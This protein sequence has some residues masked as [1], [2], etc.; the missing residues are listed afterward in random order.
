M[1]RLESHKAHQ[2]QILLVQQYHVTSQRIL[3]AQ[4]LLL[5][6]HTFIAVRLQSCEDVQATHKFWFL[7]NTNSLIQQAFRSA[8]GSISLHDFLYICLYN[9]QYL[10]PGT[11]ADCILAGSNSWQT[12]GFNSRAGDEHLTCFQTKGFPSE[13]A[14]CLAIKR[15]QEHA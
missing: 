6:S 5:R 15:G 13:N 7:Y 14:S 12:G 8:S 9:G 10:E 2:P 3:W 11:T 4:G 1:I